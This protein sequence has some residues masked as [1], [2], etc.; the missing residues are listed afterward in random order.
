MPHQNRVTP[1]GEIIAHAGRGMFMGNRGC[2]HDHAGQIRRDWRLKAWITCQLDFKDRTR[3]LLRPGHYTELFF[4][5]EATALAAGHRPCAECR[6]DDF[7]YFK[8]IWLQSNPNVALS[9]RP[10]IG[11]IDQ[12]LHAERLDA[13]GQKQTHR[14]QAANLPDYAFVRKDDGQLLSV[15]GQIPVGMDGRRLYRKEN[16][17]ARRDTERLNTR[18]NCGDP[19]GR[20]C[21]T[22]ALICKR[23]GLVFIHDLRLGAQPAQSAQKPDTKVPFSSCICPPYLVA[24]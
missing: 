18:V 24:S 17:S 2:L 4:L 6:R 8:K 12:A 23:V 3:E 13:T 19:A 7:L 9:D 21:A 1:A 22:A 11:E 14:L 16:E 5:D 10:G 20:L 15:E